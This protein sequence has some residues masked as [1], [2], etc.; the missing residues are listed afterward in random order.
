[1]SASQ[2]PYVLDRESVR[3]VDR[4]AIDEYGIP[5]IVLMENAARGLAAKDLIH[6]VRVALTGRSVSPPLFEVMSILGHTKVLQRLE[7][8][9]QHLAT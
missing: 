1:M 9:V 4:A 2:T 6:P 7:H 5:G 3:A 8:A